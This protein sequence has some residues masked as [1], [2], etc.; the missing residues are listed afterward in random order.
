MISKL[1]HVGIHD[2]LLSDYDVKIR[3][4]YNGFTIV[5]FVV[6]LIQSTLFCEVDFL[7][8]VFHFSWGLACLMGLLLHAYG[9]FSI[10]R[11]STCVLVIVLA[12]AASARIGHEY[13]PHF[14][15]FGIMVAPFIFYDLI[16]E[17]KYIFFIVLLGVITIAIVETNYFKNPEI[18]F[19]NPLPLR[20]FI[21]I[22]TIGFVAYEIV[23][24][25]RLNWLNENSINSELEKKNELL[26]QS[27]AE[28]NILLQEIHHRVKNNFQVVLS[29]IK[30]QSEDVTD[31]RAKQVF[32]DLQL[33]FSAIALMHQKMY[34]SAHIGKIDLQEF[35]YELSQQIIEATSINKEVRIEVVSEVQEISNDAIIPLSLLLNELITNSLNHGFENKSSSNSIVLEVKHTKQ[36][37]ILS[38]SDNGHWKGVPTNSNGFG[39]ELIELLTQQLQGTYSRSYDDRGTF[40]VFEFP[41]KI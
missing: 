7:A 17:W 27:N 20:L 37:I 38:Y 33:R 1:L 9:Y 18:V 10:A 16:K 29:L 22:G 24:L 4:L 8:G 31:E 13:Y 36:G 32:Q 39:L 5:G 25:V 3:K 11:F 2:A 26:K 21:L 41:E 12:G 28:K 23:F 35:L 34:Q 30:L 6:S 15:S 19:E 14:A 40:Y